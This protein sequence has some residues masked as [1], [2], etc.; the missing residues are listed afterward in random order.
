MDTDRNLNTIGGPESARE[1]D[2]ESQTSGQILLIFERIRVAI[3]DPT[4][5]PQMARFKNDGLMTGD[6]LG[7]SWGTS[8][9]RQA[10]R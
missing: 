6:G 8:Q 7:I 10:G 3:R 4:K 5:V 1:C 2:G 9:R